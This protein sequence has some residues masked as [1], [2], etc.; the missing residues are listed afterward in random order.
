MK[1]M[2]KEYDEMA[3]ALYAEGLT[4]EQI[5][6]RMGTTKGA[7]CGKLW[8]LAKKAPLPPVRRPASPEPPPDM[9]E[10]IVRRPGVTP[11]TL[12]YFNADADTL[13]RP[14]HYKQALEINMDMER[15]NK[16]GLKWGLTFHTRHLPPVPGFQ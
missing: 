3:L 1:P 12:A 10:P 11:E 13:R 16:L 4:R 9:P 5:G 7:I 2:P 14:G 15:L 6:E 8:R